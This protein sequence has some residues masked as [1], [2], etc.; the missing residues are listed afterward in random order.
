M[1]DPSKYLIQLYFL[2]QWYIIF[3]IN[4]PKIQKWKDISHHRIKKGLKLKT[5]MTWTCIFSVVSSLRSMLQHSYSN[6]RISKH[7]KPVEHLMSSCLTRHQSSYSRPIVPRQ[8]R[9][10]SLSV[11][12]RIGSAL[13][14]F[15]RSTS[16]SSSWTRRTPTIS[17]AGNQRECYRFC[18]TKNWLPRA[19]GE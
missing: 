2:R 16:S 13:L 4:K 8:D 14:P 5:S 17:S 11:S 15:V 12:W 19:D 7:N 18:R 1:V 6:R 10:T 9:R 3:I